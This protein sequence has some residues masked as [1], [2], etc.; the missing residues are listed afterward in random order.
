MLLVAGLVSICLALVPPIGSAAARQ[1]YEGIVTV[2]ESPEH[3]PA[4]CYLLTAS[5]P[6][7]C[8]GLPVVGWDWNAVDDEQSAHGTTWGS[9]KVMGTYDRKSFTLTDTPTR[10]GTTQDVSSDPDFSPACRKPIVVD[11]SQG[12]AEW[13]ALGAGDFGPFEVPGLI[14]GWVS[15]PDG[16]DESFVGNLIVRPGARDEAVNRVRLHYGGPLC[17]VERAAP[18]AARLA[19]VQSEV[20]DTAAQRALGQVLGASYDGRRGVVD[21]MLWAVDRRA[22]AYAHRRW[23]DTVGLH[24]VLNRVQ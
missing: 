17:V 19:R 16:N 2:L 10:A 7:R 20:N 12:V 13:E 21:A 8:S 24:G 18:T 23:G 5:R 9:W 1:R 11:S 4:L 6:P 22:K 14:A 3:G 15:N